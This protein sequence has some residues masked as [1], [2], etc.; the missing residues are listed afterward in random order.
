MHRLASGR[1]DG[2]RHRFG[3]VGVDV[4]DHDA[5]PPD[6]DHL[7]H[8]STEPTGGTG[9]D[10]DLPPDVVIHPADRTAD[11]GVGPF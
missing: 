10:D 8:Q 2:A 5:R 1:P 6:G 7:G 11:G 9:D 3:P 4:G